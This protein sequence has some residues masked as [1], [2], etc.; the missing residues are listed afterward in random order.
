MTAHSLPQSVVDGGDPYER[1]LRAAAATIAGDVAARSTAGP[2]RAQVAFQSQGMSGPGARPIAWL[3]PDLKTALDEARGQGASHVIFAPIGFLADHVEILY[4]L[5][6]E[7]RALAEQRGLSFARVP[8]LNADD[9]FVD[10]LA[11]LARELLA[12]APPTAKVEDA[13]E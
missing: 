6:V 5:D 12:S 1:E 4:D 13:H 3:G 7:A 10:V 11:V 8:S 2:V 9:D